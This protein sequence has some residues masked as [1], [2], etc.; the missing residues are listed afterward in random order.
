MSGRER[1][2]SEELESL[3]P[4]YQIPSMDR[5]RYVH[6]EGK[7]AYGCVVYVFEDDW[8]QFS[9]SSIQATEWLVKADNVY[10]IEEWGDGMAGNSATD[11]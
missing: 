6:V 8:E 7:H 2:L 3:T 5:I 1:E 10:Y 9:T 11:S 4:C